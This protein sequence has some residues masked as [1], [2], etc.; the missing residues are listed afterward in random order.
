MTQNGVASSLLDPR[1]Y[2]LYFYLNICFRARKVTG[3]FEKL[4]LVSKLKPFFF[5]KNPS[6]I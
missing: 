4:A 6:N 1:S 3:T 2:S 5:G